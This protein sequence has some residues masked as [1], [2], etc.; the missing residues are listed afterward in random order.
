[1]QALETDA[2][3]FKGRLAC[4]LTL[5]GVNLTPASLLRIEQGDEITLPVAGTAA[6]AAGSHDVGLGCR[7]PTNAP[8]TMSVG[9]VSVGVVAVPQ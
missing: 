1:M 6:V 9:R 4:N 8:V 7:N 2:T 3:P 5:D